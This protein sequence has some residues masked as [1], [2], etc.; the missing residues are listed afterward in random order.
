MVSKLEAMTELKG[1]DRA[2][3]AE[4]MQMALQKQ[5]EEKAA[6]NVEVLEGMSQAMLGQQDLL[7]KAQTDAFQKIKSLPGTNF[8]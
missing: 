1:S 2:L 5:A 4:M 3:I 8:T 6:S 7:I